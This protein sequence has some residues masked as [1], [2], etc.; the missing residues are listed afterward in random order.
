MHCQLTAQLVIIFII[1]LI[2]MGKTKFN[3]VLWELFITKYLSLTV[4]DSKPCII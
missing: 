4:M 1:P 3:N 2:H